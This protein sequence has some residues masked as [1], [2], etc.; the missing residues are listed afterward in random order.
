MVRVGF[1]LPCEEPF[2]S[3]PPIAEKQKRKEGRNLPFLLL[4]S[5]GIRLQSGGQGSAPVK[6]LS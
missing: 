3:K 2:V 5:N 6:V 1:A 4:R